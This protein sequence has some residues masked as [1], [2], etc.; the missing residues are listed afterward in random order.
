[1]LGGE[2]EGVVKDINTTQVGELVDQNWVKI[3]ALGMMADSSVFPR[4]VL[5]RSGLFRPP[6]V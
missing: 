5:H 2:G 1:M 4:F 6:S 3:K